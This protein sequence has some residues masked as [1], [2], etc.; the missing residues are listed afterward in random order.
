MT[1]YATSRAHAL[2]LHCQRCA[3][4]A[5]SVR[6]HSTAAIMLVRGEC[7]A[8]SLPVHH[9]FPPKRGTCCRGALDSRTCA[10]GPCIRSLWPEGSTSQR[11]RLLPRHDAVGSR[12]SVVRDAVISVPRQLYCQKPLHRW[13]QPA[14]CSCTC[15]WSVCVT[16]LDANCFSLHTGISRRGMHTPPPCQKAK[17]ELSAQFSSSAQHIHARRFIELYAEI[18][19]LLQTPYRL[20]CDQAPH[21]DRAR[22]AQ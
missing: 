19:E 11:S 10:R 9:N 22:T 14:A 3:C 16:R 8:L 4:A 2:I 20:L 21:G 18:A 13:P 1:P 17:D 6:Q 5:M 12:R 7:H 15:K